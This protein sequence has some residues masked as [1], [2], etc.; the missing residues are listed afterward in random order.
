[1]AKYDDFGRPIYETAEEYLKGANDVIKNPSSLH[2]VEAEDGD[3]CYYLY[4][5]NEFVVV[6]PEGEIRTYFKPDDGISYF[7]RQMITVYHFW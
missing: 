4:S 2:K 6:S 7:N 3:D 5:T 1:M